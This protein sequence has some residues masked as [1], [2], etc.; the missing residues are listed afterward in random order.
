MIFLSACRLCM[1]DPTV[2]PEGCWGCSPPVVCS[3][4]K[5]TA[6]DNCI[7]AHTILK[8]LET[9]YQGLKIQKHFR[10]HASLVFQY[11]LSSPVKDN[12]PFVWEFL[13]PP[14]VRTIV[15]TMQ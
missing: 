11:E 2:T 5:E 14:L 13:A 7:M 1:F 6:E 15:E 3:G 8:M 4:V 9:P 12:S 10:E